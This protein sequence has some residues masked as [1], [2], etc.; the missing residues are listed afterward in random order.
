[1]NEGY[2][3]Y[4]EGNTLGSD[5]YPHEYEDYEGFDFPV[6]GPYEEFPI[7][8]SGRVYSGGSPGADRV[9]FNTKGTLADLITHTGASDD[10]FLECK[11]DT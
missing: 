5:E 8:P 7:L 4:K 11:G 10:D 3:L 9:V 2:S 1:V 6:S